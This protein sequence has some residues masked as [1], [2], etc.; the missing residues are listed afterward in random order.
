MQATVLAVQ[1]DVQGVY[2]IP[3]RDTLSLAALIRL[4]G[5]APLAA[6]GFLMAPLYRAR[7]W[8]E[9]SEFRYDLNHWRFHFNGTLCGDRAAAE[10]GYEPA[11]SVSWETMRREGA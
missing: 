2:N 1:S 5:H 8:V 6:P 10:L 7:A 9:G 11:T 3:G 4:A